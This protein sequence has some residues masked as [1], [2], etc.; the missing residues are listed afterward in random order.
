MEEGWFGFCSKGGLWTW[1]GWFQWS[2]RGGSPAMWTEF[3][4]SV[5][6]RGGGFV[7]VYGSMCQWCLGPVVTAL[8][9]HEVKVHTHFTGL[10]PERAFLALIAFSSLTHIYNMG[11]REWKRGKKSRVGQEREGRKTRQFLKL[12][13]TAKFWINPVFLLL[14]PAFNLLVQAGNLTVFPALVELLPAQPCGPD[15]CLSHPHLLLYPLVFNNSLSIAA[16]SSSAP[17]L[18]SCSAKEMEVISQEPWTSLQLLISCRQCP[19]FC[20]SQRKRCPCFSPAGPSSP[21]VSSSYLPLN[22]GF[23]TPYSGNFLRQPHLLS[24]L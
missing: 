12:L 16:S 20:L 13:L 21:A 15:R 3:P 1:A 14:C 6:A 2:V 10:D 19:Y 23:P 22:C 11:P 5:V 17:A 8:G 4:G 9:I 18:L 7:V 24:Q